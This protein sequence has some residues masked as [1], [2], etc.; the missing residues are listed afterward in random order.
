MI[1]ARA[2]P[3]RWP[4]SLRAAGGSAP[5]SRLAS[6]MGARSPAWARRASFNA[7]LSDAAANAASAAATIAS[8][9]SAL[10]AATCFGS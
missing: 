1:R 6:A 10:S 9:D 2:A 8:R 4:A 3:M 7:A 5:I